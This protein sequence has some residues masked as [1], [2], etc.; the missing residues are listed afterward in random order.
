MKRGCQRILFAVAVQTTACSHFRINSHSFQL[1]LRMP[2]WTAFGGKISPA[3]GFLLSWTRWDHCRDQSGSFPWFVSS[4]ASLHARVYL[5]SGYQ[6]TTFPAC[7]VFARS[8]F[9]SGT[10]G[11]KRRRTGRPVTHACIISLEP[12]D[13]TARGGKKTS[14]ERTGSRCTERNAGSF[15]FVSCSLAFRN[16]CFFKRRVRESAWRERNFH[17]C[18]LPTS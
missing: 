9:S 6:S 17:E 2:C 15:R 3:M 7:G 10:F 16:V 1:H 14:G 13:S 5:T 12:S 18:F 11:D 8:R 4:V